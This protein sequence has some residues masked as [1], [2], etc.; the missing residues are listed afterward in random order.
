MLLTSKVTY[1]VSVWIT[2]FNDVPIIIHDPH[3]L[4]HCFGLLHFLNF[5]GVRLKVSGKKI[6]TLQQNNL[7]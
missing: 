7:S 6:V 3:C 2:S 5:G 4:S 1:C